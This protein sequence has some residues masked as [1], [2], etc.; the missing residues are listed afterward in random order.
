MKRDRRL[1]GLSSEHHQALVLARS[2]DQHERPWTHDDGV[3]LGQRFDDELAPHF[4][5]E[6][7]VLLPALRRVGQDE[8]ADRTAEDHALLRGHVTS[9]RAGDGRAALAFAL[10][11]TDHVRFEE[12]ELFPA[13]EELL[14]SAVLD[15][16]A[17]RA[18]KEE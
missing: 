12:R 6:E 2:L 14:P 1:R 8:L 4:R 5:I 16:V 11:L 9:A 15:E 13:C 7:E 17:R 3:A 18:P 10:R